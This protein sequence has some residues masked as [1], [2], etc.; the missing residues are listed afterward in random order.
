MTVT[1][2]EQVA[3]NLNRRSLLSFAEQGGDRNLEELSQQ[4]EQRGLQGGDRVDHDPQV[5]S[6]Q[7]PSSRIAVGKSAPHLVEDIF[8]A[9]DRLPHH[10]RPGVL[11]GLADPFAPGHL[12]DSYMSM[13]VLDNQDIAAKERGVSTT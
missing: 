1:D 4:I 6:L 2:V 11:Q 8:V 3:K 13:T 10:H 5:E 9:A 7:T 12:A